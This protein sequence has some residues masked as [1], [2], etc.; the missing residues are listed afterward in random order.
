MQAIELPIEFPSQRAA[1]T[2]RS[3]RFAFAI[4]ALCYA[5]LTC[6]MY[7]YNVRAAPPLMWETRHLLHRTLL[8]DL[9]GLHP[10]TEVSA[11]YGPILTYAPSVTYWLLRPLGASHEQ[12]YFMSHLLLNLAGLWCVYYVLSRAQMPERPRL[13]AFALLAIAG[14]GLWMGVNGVLVRYLFPFASLLLGHRTVGWMLSR[15]S[16]VASWGGAV[17]SVLLLIGCE[18]PSFSRNRR[19]TSLSR[20]SVTPC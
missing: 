17:I 16:Y 4:V 20:G 9:Y 5:L 10:Y 12:A 7:I 8:M 2:T 15:R 6:A 18:Y 3:I 14:F 13:V 11:E 19:G 1:G